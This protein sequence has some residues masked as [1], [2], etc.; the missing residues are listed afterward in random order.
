[1][2]FKSAFEGLNVLYTY[3]IRLTEPVWWRA[4][5]FYQALLNMATNIRIPKKR[6]GISCVIAGFRREVDENCALMNHY[7]MTSGNTL[8]TFRANL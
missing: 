8:P 4:R 1:M 3:K 2:G 7:A 6:R 5:F